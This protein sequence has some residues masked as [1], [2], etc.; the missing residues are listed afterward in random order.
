MVRWFG[1]RFIAVLF[2]SLSLGF[3]GQAQFAPLPQPVPQPQPGKQPKPVP[4]PQ[5][6][7]RPQPI[8]QPQPAPWPTPAPQPIPQPEPAR[9]RI[10]DAYYQGQIQGSAFADRILEIFGPMENQ[11]YQ[12]SEGLRAGVARAGGKYSAELLIR[13]SQL[14]P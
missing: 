1:F 6:Q 8:P 9:E 7:P 4:Q 3:A 10:R 14:N 12:I 5:P 2:L 11:R 13:L